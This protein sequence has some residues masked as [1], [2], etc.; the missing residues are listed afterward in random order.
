MILLCSW[1]F[2][3]Y[4]AF[5]DGGGGG[6]DDYYNDLYLNLAIFSVILVVAGGDGQK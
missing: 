1:L 5:V 6:D 4:E 2:F 3:K